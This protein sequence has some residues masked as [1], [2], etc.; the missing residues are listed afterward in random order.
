MQQVIAREK[1]L[2]EDGIHVLCAENLFFLPLYD[3]RPCPNFD[4]TNRDAVHDGSQIYQG[5]LVVV[6]GDCEHVCSF[7]RHGV[8]RQH[9]AW[10][11]HQLYG[12]RVANALVECIKLGGGLVRPIPTRDP[13]RVAKRTAQHFGKAHLVLV[14]ELVLVGVQ[15]PRFKVVFQNSEH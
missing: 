6:C 8:H 7:F 3:S 4:G 15:V 1:G 11:Y 5:F 12:S 13:H 9:V 2:S 10:R 14:Q